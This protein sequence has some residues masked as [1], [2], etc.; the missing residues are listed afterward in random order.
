MSRSPR[1]RIGKRS[2][3][4]GRGETYSVTR[5]EELQL[6]QVYSRGL[7]PY[8]VTGTNHQKVVEGRAPRHR[9]VLMGRVAEVGADCVVVEMSDAH[10]IAPLKEGDGLVFDAADWRS[11]GEPEEGGRVYEAH[12]VA[13]WQSA[14]AV[15]Q[16]RDSLRSHPAR[17]SGLAQQRSGRDT[18]GA[19]VYRSVGAGARQPV[20]VRVVAHAG[21]PLVTEWSLVRTPERERYRQLGNAARD[22][23]ESRRFRS[24]PCANSLA[25]WGTRRMNWGASRSTWKALRSL[26]YRC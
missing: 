16:S 17:R 18:R 8:F 7:G 6:E 25:G 19:A 10:E 9:G 14:T 22:G 2:M 12:A 13:R 11:P 21:S 15:R 26:P 20:Q 3:R 5:A 23:A 1:T 4:P 24:N